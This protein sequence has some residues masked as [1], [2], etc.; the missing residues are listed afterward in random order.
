MCID[1]F[2]F[3]NCERCQKKTRIESTVDNVQLAVSLSVAVKAYKA[4]QE[5]NSRS[6]TIVRR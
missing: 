5:R 4:V 1:C 3:V 6:T 2:Y